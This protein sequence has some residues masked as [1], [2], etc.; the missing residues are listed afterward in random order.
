MR[1]KRLLFAMVVLPVLTV[2]VLFARAPE[3]TESQT[4]SP[5]QIALA[6]L[7]SR[8]SAS[9]AGAMELRHVATRE[10]LGAYHVRYQETANGIPVFGG[11]VTVNLRKANNE[12]TLVLDRRAGLAPAA[13]VNFAA[14]PIGASQAQAAVGAGSLRAA[15]QETQVYFPAG[16]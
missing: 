8:A 13:G 6:H 14:P 4:L 2:G 7:R 1:R 16:K 15:A 3:R 10:S 11:S 12:A 9:I 5:E